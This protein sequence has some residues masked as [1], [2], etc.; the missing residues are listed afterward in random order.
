MIWVSF[1]LPFSS[2]FLGYEIIFSVAKLDLTLVEVIGAAF[3]VGMGIN[4][5]VGLLI[6]PIVHCSMKN[7]YIQISFSLIVSML[8]WLKN[9][10]IKQ[11][12]LMLR[13]STLFLLSITISALLYISYKAYFVFDGMMINSGKNDLFL[14]VSYIASFAKGVNNDR[15]LFNIALPLCYNNKG[16]SEFL[17]PYYTALLHVNGLSVQAAILIVTSLLLISIVLLQ[18]SF[19]YRL[20]KCQYASALSV[21]VAF[22]SGGFGFL[23][24]LNSEYR[25]DPS[26]DYVFNLGKNYFNMWGHPIIHCILT[27]RVI[28]HAMSLSIF[29]FLLLEIDQNIFAS[30][31]LAFVACIRPQNAFGLGIIY[32]L[33]KQKQIL[34][35]MLYSVPTILIIYMLKMKITYRDAIFWYQS[36]RNSIFPLFSYQFQVL[37]L[38]FICLIFAVPYFK[39]KLFISY[40]AFYILT[41]VSLQYQ[42]RFNFFVQLS[43]IV[44]IFIAISF[45]GMHKFLKRWNSPEVEGSLQALMLIATIFMC[46]SSIT[47]IIARINDR[48]VAWDYFDEDIGGWIID[49]TKPDSSFLSQMP[50]WYPWNP[51]N[52]IAGRVGYIGHYFHM[53]SALFDNKN[54]ETEE[55]EF[56]NNCKRI[57]NVNYYLILKE[58]SWID[59]ISHCIGNIFNPVYE[60]DKYYILQ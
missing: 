13:I 51:A 26:I 57:A 47:G 29:T 2:F 44:P 60:N 18:Y 14:E 37:G 48:F 19:T 50:A 41:T 1:L 35:R 24:F 59:N 40:L 5:F 53:P 27:S 9:K 15:S 52:A 31:I 43:T 6:N 58:G 56:L 10:K 23:R 38:L 45:S 7:C 25:H 16:Y 11:N 55:N 49:N 3:P 17:P 32:I 54:Y 20:S 39:Y 42:L 36:Y 34:L 12:S 4:S 30:I 22:F 33:Y 46:L 28:L 8:L 21:P